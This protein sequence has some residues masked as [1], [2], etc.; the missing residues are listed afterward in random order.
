[1]DL[2]KSNCF[3]IWHFQILLNALQN[4]LVLSVAILLEYETLFFAIW[5]F[6]TTGSAVEK[7]KEKEKEKEKEK[8]GDIE[9]MGEWNPIILSWNYCLGCGFIDF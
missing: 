1:M 3:S 9:G 6:S 4:A 2:S 7:K 8:R 5:F